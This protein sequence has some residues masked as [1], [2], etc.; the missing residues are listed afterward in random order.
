[1]QG[2]GEEFTAALENLKSRGSNLL[3]LSDPGAADG[4]CTHLL[5]DDSEGRRRLLVSAGRG[6]YDDAGDAPDP[7]RLGVVEASETVRSAAASSPSPSSPAGFPQT[8]EAGTGTGTGAAD[9]PEWYSRLESLEQL[10]RLATQ[11]NR[12]LRRFETYDPQPGEIRL[13]FDALDPFVDATADR[14]LFRFIH[15]VTT[16]LRGAGG[17]G[18]YHLSSAADPVTINTFRPLFDASIE[19]RA[20][21]DGPQQRWTLTESGLRTDWLPVY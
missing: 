20:T 11:I 5:G 7:G 19:V 13:C 17:M 9:H 21:V 2:P 18:H 12:H 1:M 6:S 15:V 4:M 3:V 14:D 16:R 10:P 8:V